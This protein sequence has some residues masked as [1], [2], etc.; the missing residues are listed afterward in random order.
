M[1][2]FHAMVTGVTIKM[3]NLACP[4]TFAITGQPCRSFMA[5]VSFPISWILNGYYCPGL[6]WSVCVNGAGSVWTLVSL[7]MVTSNHLDQHML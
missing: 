5:N 6:Y 3:T 4:S 2:I 1:A 7:F